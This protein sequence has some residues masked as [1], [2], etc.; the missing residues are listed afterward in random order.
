MMGYGYMGWAGAWVWMAVGI[1]LLLAVI[2]LVTIAVV[3]WSGPRPPAA[4]P[5]PSADARQILAMR[6]ARGE[7]DHDEYLARLQ[8]LAAGKG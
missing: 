6:F 5:D 2:A 3:R 7:I 8:T 4:G 1:L